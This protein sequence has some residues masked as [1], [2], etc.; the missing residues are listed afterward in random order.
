[1]SAA[2]PFDLVVFDFDGT[3]VDSARD[4]ARCMHLAFG[5]V[6][7]SVAEVDLLGEM[8]HPL[9]DVWRRFT[10]EVPVG[11]A[12]ERFV[13]RYRD[14]HHVHGNATTAVFPGVVETLQRLAHLRL[15]IATTKP[16]HRARQQ[17]EFFNIHGYFHH[18]QGTDDFL[19]KPDPEIV[20]RVLRLLPAEPSRVLFVGDTERDVEAGRAAGCATAAATWGGRDRTFLAALGPDHLLDRFEDLLGVVAPRYG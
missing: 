1:M 18:I 6:E 4:L 14:H 10:G 11:A 3:L 2:R 9:D 16:T 13:E 17:A 12:W 15:A 19:P 7:R 8:G 5:D 20:Y